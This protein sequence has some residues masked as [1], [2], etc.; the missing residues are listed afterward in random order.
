MLVVEML[1]QSA[2]LEDLVETLQ[3]R[4]TERG[5]EIAH[6]RLIGCRRADDDR[7]AL[8]KTVR[9]MAPQRHRDIDVIG[10]HHAAFAAGQRRR[11]GKVEDGDVAERSDERALVFRAD[12]LG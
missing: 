6:A 12:R 8:F 7:D 9:A 11:L 1:G 5:R 2:P 4:E 10:H 3:L